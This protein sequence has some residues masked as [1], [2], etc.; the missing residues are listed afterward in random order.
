MENRADQ[1]DIERFWSKV[2]V[3]DDDSCW[4]WKAS[5]MNSGYGQFITR[6]NGKTYALSCHRL[7]YEITFG[8]IPD[9]LLVCHHCDNKICVN[10]K[11]LFLGTAS[12]NLY[13][14]V[15]KGRHK[16][17]SKKMSGE[18]NPRAK[19]SKDDIMKIRSLFSKGVTRD[20][21]YKKY[22]I[23]YHTQICL[24]INKKTWKHI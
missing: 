17:N 2:N 18:R 7:S 21:L 11:H 15:R 23:V 6:H 10:P 1:K 12:D 16:S 9:G 4:E 24:I 13:D 22:P 3:C 8:N 5:I 14:A 20:E 19:L